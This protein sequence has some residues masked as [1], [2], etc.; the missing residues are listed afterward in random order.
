[1]PGELLHRRPARTS[2]ETLRDEEVTQVAKP[3]VRQLRA[4]DGSIERVKQAA[5]GPGLSLA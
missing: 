3:R 1:M 2:R 4:F 5:M